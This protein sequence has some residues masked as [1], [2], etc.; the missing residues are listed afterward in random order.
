MRKIKFR[1]WNKNFEEMSVVADLDFW[2]NDVWIIDPDVKNLNQMDRSEVVLMQWTGLTDNN[3]VE[4]YEGDI[5][6]VTYYDLTHGIIGVVRF[7]NGSFYIDCDGLSLYTWFDYEVE[8]LGNIFENK[9]LLKE[10]YE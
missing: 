3:G 6:R 5:V 8:V 7:D 9:E 1:A 2:A 4:V 10:V